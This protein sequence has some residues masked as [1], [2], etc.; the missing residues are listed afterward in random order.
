MLM[1]ENATVMPAG[2]PAALKL[3]AELK[4]ALRVVVRIAAPLD[5]AA[6]SM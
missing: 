1:G 4:V 5:P 6:M 3:T 2:A